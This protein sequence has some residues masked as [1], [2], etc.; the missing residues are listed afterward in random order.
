MSMTIVTQGVKLSKSQ[1]LLLLVMEMIGNIQKVPDDK[2]DSYTESATVK[3]DV[4]DI[5]FD[6]L[7]VVRGQAGERVMCLYS[8]CI[9]KLRTEL[10]RIYRLPL[11]QED[12][13][14]LCSHLENMDEFVMGSW[15]AKLGK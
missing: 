10:N 7:I 6:V 2:I 14:E 5:K 15:Y 11:R 12:H 8:R 9:N 4:D 3:V 13:V 1:I